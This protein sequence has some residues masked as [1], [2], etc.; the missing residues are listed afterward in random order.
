MTKRNLCIWLLLPLLLV[1]C[2]RRAEVLP[3]R[4]T[5]AT[6]SPA[7]ANGDP[8]Y[9]PGQLM[10]EAETEEEA[11]EI[12]GLYGI[13]LIRFRN[14]IAVYQTDED[15]D[16]VIERGRANGWPALEKDGLLTIS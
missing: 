2:G 8:L 1:G 16:T 13:E 3:G 6:L 15:L 5:E 9:V 14:G 12:A 4:G 7:P 11:L 10:G